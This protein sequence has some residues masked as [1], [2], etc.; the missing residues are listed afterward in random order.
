MSTL[1][2][3]KGNKSVTGKLTWL[4]KYDVYVRDQVRQP[5]DKLG[6]KHGGEPLDDTLVALLPR[7]ACVALA[8]N[9]GWCMG[10]DCGS[11]GI[12]ANGGSGKGAPPL[13]T[14]QDDFAETSVPPPPHVVFQTGPG[15]VRPTYGVN[16]LACSI[17]FRRQIKADGAISTLLG[18]VILSDIGYSG[19]KSG[20]PPVTYTSK[21][22]VDVV[23]MLNNK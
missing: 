14:E 6:G 9:G 2:T 5:G 8:G 17:R 15:I 22:P 10:L 3:L 13:L 21:D 1:P 7:P 18:L 19:D 4:G 11:G 23:D 20:L 12:G 16:G